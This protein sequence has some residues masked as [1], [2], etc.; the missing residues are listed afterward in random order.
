MSWRFLWVDIYS[1]ICIYGKFTDLEAM[2][3]IEYGE[4]WWE[5]EDGVKV[6]QFMRLKSPRRYKER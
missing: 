5:G 6:D 3:F 2:F 4:I 1:F